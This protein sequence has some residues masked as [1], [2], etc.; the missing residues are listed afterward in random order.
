MPLVEDIAFL[1][2]ETIAFH[3]AR[4]DLQNGDYFGLPVKV[5]KPRGR[6][7]YYYDQNRKKH[8]IV[9]HFTMGYLGG[10]LANLSRD[11]FHV[12]VPFVIAR[13]GVIVSLFDPDKWSYHLSRNAVGGNKYCSSRSIAIEMTGLGP[14]DRS[15]DWMFNYYGSRYCRATQAEHFLALDTPY[16]GYSYYTR[17]TDAQYDSLN[18]LL[19]LLTD[20]YDIP[21]HFLDPHARFDLFE[22]SHDA[23]NYRGICGHVNYQPP[24]VK[25]DIGPAFAWEKIGG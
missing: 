12:S 16:R 5:F 6:Q 9:L 10:D 13:S 4:G 24:T 21:R 18:Q 14:L 19:D 2:R 1:E 17:F 7:G 23:R 11:N 25:T 22:T 3:T 15:G 8:Q 20:R